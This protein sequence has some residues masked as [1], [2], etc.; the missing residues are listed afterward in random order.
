MSSAPLIVDFLV[1]P[2]RW[3]HFRSSQKGMSMKCNFPNQLFSLCRFLK[4]YNLGFT[5]WNVYILKYTGTNGPHIYRFYSHNFDYFIHADMLRTLC[6]PLSWV[7]AQ[8]LNLTRDTKYESLRV[9]FSFNGS[10][11]LEMHCISLLLSNC[12]SSF[13]LEFFP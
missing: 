13:T 6:I 1:N 12:Y 11:F 3:M 2:F 10:K 7:M 8:K 9:C 5:K 4:D